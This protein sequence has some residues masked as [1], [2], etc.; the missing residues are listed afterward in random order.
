MLRWRIHDPRGDGRVD[1]GQNAQGAAVFGRPLGHCGQFV[2]Q[3]VRDQS[4]T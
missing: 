2:A 1:W 3:R 4:V